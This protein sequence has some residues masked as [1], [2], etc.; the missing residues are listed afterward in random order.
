MPW[1][2]DLANL[3]RVLGGP[4]HVGVAARRLAVPERR[5]RRI[6]RRDGWWQPHGDVIAPPGTPITSWTRAA[7]ALAQVQGPD[8]AAPALCAL[9]RWSGADLLG[10]GP[11]AP[12]RIQV[13]V[14]AERRPRSDTGPT[15]IRCRGFGPEAVTSHRGLSVAS[16]SWLVRSAAAVASVPLLTDLVI[17]LCQQRFLDLAA[18]RAHHA[19]WARYP[20]RAR[21]SEVLARLDDAGRTDS[22]IELR[23]RERLVRDGVPLDH[24]QVPVPCGLVTVHLDLGIEAIRFGIDLD[25]MLAHS[26]REQL[27]ADVR[28]SNALASATDDWRIVRATWEDL[29]RDWPAFLALVRQV[30]AEQSRRHLGQPW[31]CPKDLRRG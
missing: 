9:G 13:L 24:G 14:P 22:S 10:V 12:S 19:A 5:I 7:A 8:P 18:L 4:V 16:P 15:I 2:R 26:S 17:D 1:P 20:G 27:R 6:A 11:G 3:C 21:V 31:P 30:I 29:D 28:R 23:T 25:S